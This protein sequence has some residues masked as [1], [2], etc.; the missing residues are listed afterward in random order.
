MEQYV[1]LM[2]LLVMKVELKYVLMMFWGTICGTRWSK[3]DVFVVCKQLG[4]TN[5]G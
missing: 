3:T 2:I 5:S 1:L 4:Y